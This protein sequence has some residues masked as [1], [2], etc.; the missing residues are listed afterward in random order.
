VELFY[1][2]W[3]DIGYNFLVGEDGF[4]YEGRGW[5]HVGSHTKGYNSQ[6]LGTSVIG[7]YMKKN[8]NKMALDGKYGIKT[9]D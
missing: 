7:D 2:G 1:L 3:V 5:T 9:G 4:V 8:P 6:S